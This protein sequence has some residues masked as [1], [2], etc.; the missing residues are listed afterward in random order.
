MILT[1]EQAL[2]VTGRVFK[3]IEA[4][5]LGGELRIASLAAGAALAFSALND[6]KEKGEDVAHLQM[7]LIVQ[8]AIVDEK[9]RPLFDAE[10]AAR[11]LDS[12]SLST[13]TLV[14]NETFALMPGSVAAGNSKASPI[15]A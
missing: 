12:V 2:K 3:N 9:D 4:P 11:F 1:R 14:M 5:E 10:S 13:L 6:R 8:H 7:L 15:A